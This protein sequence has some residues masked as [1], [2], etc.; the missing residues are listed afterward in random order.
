[1]RRGAATIERAKPMTLDEWAE[2]DEDVEG[3]LVDGVLEGE[4][5]ANFLHEIVVSWL[6]ARAQDGGR[7]SAWAQ[8]RPLGL[9]PRSHAGTARLAGTRRATPR[10]RGGLA[11][12]PRRA[13]R[14][15]GQAARLRPQRCAGGPGRAG[16]RCAT[17]SSPS[18]LTL[19]GES[20]PRS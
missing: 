2:L 8:A 15:G 13:P 17:G 18:H 3:E 20:R 1:M 7:A 6:N 14:P 16:A 10:G 5:V 11:A 19:G 12:S 4:E 9:P